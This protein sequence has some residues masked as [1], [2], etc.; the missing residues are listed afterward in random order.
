MLSIGRRNDCSSLAMSWSAGMMLAGKAQS[1]NRP[2]RN[3]DINRYPKQNRARNTNL[4]W[5]YI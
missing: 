1:R 5:H 2:D 4:N 3:T